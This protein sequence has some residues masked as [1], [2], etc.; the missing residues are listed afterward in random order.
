[1]S[2]LYFLEDPDRIVIIDLGPVADISG[3]GNALRIG[4][5]SCLVVGA[6]LLAAGIIGLVIGRKRSAPA[7][8]PPGGPPGGY[9]PAS[10]SGPPPGYRRDRRRRTIHRDS[11]HLTIRPD[12]RRDRPKPAHRGRLKPAP[13]AA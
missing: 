2:L 5:I 9:P 7:G 4:G 3:I 11:P 13:G 6:V 8:M 12:I 10:Q 1:M